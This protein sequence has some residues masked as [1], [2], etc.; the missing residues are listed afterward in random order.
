MRP[1]LLI[2]VFQRF[3][4]YLLLQHRRHSFGR[5]TKSFHEL[6]LFHRDVK[7][8]NI[9]LERKEQDGELCVKLLD[10]GLATALDSDEQLTQIGAIMGTA[11]YMA[12]EQARGEK[13][14]A[15]SDLFAVGCV[16]YRMLTG[17]NPFAGPNVTVI[18]A[19]T[20]CDDPQ[21]VLELATDAPVPMV[22]LTERL[23]SKDPAK[24]PES[25]RTL[26]QELAALLNASLD[27]SSQQ[28]HK[29]R[30]VTQAP[31]CVQAPVA[32]STA[33]N[34]YELPWWT[35]RRNRLVRIAIFGFIGACLLSGI[36]ITIQ[37]RNGQPRAIVKAIPVRWINDWGPAGRSSS[38]RI[39]NRRVS[40]P[41]LP[42]ASMPGRKT[43][44]K[45]RRGEAS[46]V[47][48]CQ[49]TCAR[50]IPT[51]ALPAID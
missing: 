14:D 46:R 42:T 9:W 35:V 20:V 51:R 23:L 2:D 37:D 11:G 1:E 17:V 18:L 6:P 12:P 33:V 5:P 38:C 43:P 27:S 31:R 4:A 26:A 39:W 19:K 29:P 45:I 25:A 34:W 41:R 7:P 50:P 36:I 40:T 28:I 44:L 49:Y 10:S 13:T 24:R 47:K 3:D 8:A 32:D 22:E 48:L 21:P 15:R 30:Q 16:L